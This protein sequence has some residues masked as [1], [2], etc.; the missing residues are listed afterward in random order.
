[1]FQ[2]S[3]LP[4]E[5]FLNLILGDARALPVAAAAGMIHKLEHH[6]DIVI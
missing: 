6:N 4:F 2:N 5:M 3:K 1:M